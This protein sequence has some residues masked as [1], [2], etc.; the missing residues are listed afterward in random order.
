MIEAFEALM[1]GQKAQMVFTD[2]PYN[3]PI[4]GN[5]SGL[6]RTR[7]VDLMKGSGEMSEEAFTKF[8]AASFR[9]LATH[10]QNG[11]IHFVCMDWRHLGQVL[12]AGNDVYDEVKNICV[13]NK[14]NAGMGSLY[15]SQHE[16]VFVF[17]RGTGA[18]IN[19]VELGKHGRNRTN[20]WTY[21][22]V[23]TFRAGRMDDL[24][25]HP[26]VKPVAMV[27]DAI[28]DCSRR[29]GIVLDPFVGS[30]TIFIAA[31]RTGRRAYGLELDPMYV[32]T[33]IR[34]WQAETGEAA[35]H[36][37]SGLSFGEM[38]VARIHEVAIADTSGAPGSET[39]QTR[40]ATDV[41]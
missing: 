15:R 22:G 16:L 35:R 4:A 31:G 19:N 23:N 3:V 14:T 38:E 28:K 30:G 34:R 37:E 32:D 11:S 27:A 12:A 24:A 6:D 41:R 39:S 33:A 21:P 7:H 2:P 9:N 36:A 18:H 26:T 25:L 40:G 20:V 1:S 17:K 13:W 10:S 8:L 5:V 29:N